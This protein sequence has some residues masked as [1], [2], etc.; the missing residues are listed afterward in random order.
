MTKAQLREELL[1]L[2]YDQRLEFAEML[3]ASEDNPPL[4]DWQRRALDAALEDYRERPGGE[5]SWDEV[6]AEL[7]PRR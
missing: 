7:W 3:V 6:R 5:Q 2:P 1:K 4:Q